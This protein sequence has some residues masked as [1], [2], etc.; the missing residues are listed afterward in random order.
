ML[1]FFIFCYHFKHD[2]QIQKQHLIINEK[3]NYTIMKVDFDNNSN[4]CLSISISMKKREFVNTICSQ[5][6]FLHNIVSLFYFFEN[7]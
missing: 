4:Q 1:I 2:C 3:T 5:T 7:D 6:L